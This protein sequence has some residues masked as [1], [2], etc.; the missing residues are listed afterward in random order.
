MGQH[1]NTSVGSF[2]L[3][4]IGDTIISGTGYTGEKGEKGD[5][6]QKGSQ[7]VVGNRGEMGTCGQIPNSKWDGYDIKIENPDKSWGE[8]IN[9][10]GSKGA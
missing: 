8:S 4:K 7:G 9:L 6:G 5:I 10:R 1:L 2:Q 3:V